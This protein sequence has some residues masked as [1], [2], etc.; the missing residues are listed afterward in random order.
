M[1]FAEI[2]NV[3]AAALEVP[4]QAEPAAG[5]VVHQPPNP[6]FAATVTDA[7]VEYSVKS[8]GTLPD[9]EVLPL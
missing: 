3:L 4:P 9:P 2:V 5:C 1:V 6:V 8:V 7:P